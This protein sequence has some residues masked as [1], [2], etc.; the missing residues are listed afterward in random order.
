MV[1]SAP[2]A[3]YGQCHL[4]CG[5][6]AA[7]YVLVPDEDGKPYRLPTCWS[8]YQHACDIAASN[9]WP[10]YTLRVPGSLLPFTAHPPEA[11]RP[12]EPIDELRIW[13]R[14]EL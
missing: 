13:A 11:R 2:L 3:T 8:C 9:R 12:F 5:R 7:Y 14:E 10:P 4:E 1:P 6:V